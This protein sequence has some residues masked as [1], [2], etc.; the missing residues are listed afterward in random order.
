[1]WLGLHRW[2]K[3]IMIGAAGIPLLQGTCDPAV[4]MVVDT[5]LG[6]ASSINI[7]IF[8]TFIFSLQRVILQSFP[9]AD[10]LQI[11]LGG[12]PQPFFP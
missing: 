3:K 8:Q 4:G 6:V 1:M 2:R 7:S 10:L 12:N 9:S 5:A 11:L